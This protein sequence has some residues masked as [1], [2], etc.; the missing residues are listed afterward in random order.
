MKLIKVNI[1]E[2]K[3]NIYI[4]YEKLFPELE[5][6]SYNRIKETYDKGIAD[7]FEIIV[8]NN[9]VGFI[10]ANHIENNPYIQLDYFAIFEKYQ[11]KGYGTKAL[12]MLKEV[13]KEYIGIFIEIEKVGLGESREENQVREK[14][15]S[16][17]NNIGFIKL[18]FD[19]DLFTVIYSAHMLYSNPKETYNENIKRDI[20]EFYTTILGE[21]RANKHCKII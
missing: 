11:N 12:K 17:Y 20:Y 6:K 18:D 1:E 7:I 2:F 9:I 3:E 21:A 16:F 4:E 10:I 8:E 5:R 19:L 15:E 14:R 13:Y